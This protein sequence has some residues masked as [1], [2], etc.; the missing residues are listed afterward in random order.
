MPSTLQ[1]VQ[2]AAQQLLAKLN[3]L[4]IDALSASLT[5]LAAD[6]RTDL[7]SGDLHLALT[8]S[9]ELL[10]TLNDSVRAADL[11]GLTADLR[12]T[13]G[14]LRDLAQDRDL[15]RVLANAAVASDHLAAAT[16]RLGPLI[17]ALQATAQRTDNGAADLQQGLLPILRD[18]QAA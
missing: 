12:R 15:R 7:D 3:R 17:A 8:R 4:D 10:R 14:T 1:Q 18:A 16:A 5:G 2:D 11:P 13:S 6:L 9:A